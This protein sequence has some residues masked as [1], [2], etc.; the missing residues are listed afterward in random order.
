[1][2]ME[3]SDVQ[4]LVDDIS[5]GANHLLIHLYRC[6]DGIQNGDETGIGW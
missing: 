6:T 5:W 1:M 2:E 4:L 3:P